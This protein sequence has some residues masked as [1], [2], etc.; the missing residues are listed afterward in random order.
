MSNH[1]NTA[2]GSIDK[3]LGDHQSGSRGGSVKSKDQD[4]LSL[5]EK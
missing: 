3:E 2:L 5:I 1:Q 4:K